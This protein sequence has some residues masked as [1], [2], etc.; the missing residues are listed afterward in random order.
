METKTWMTAKR[1]ARGPEAANAELERWRRVRAE[2]EASAPRRA[3]T[4]ANEGAMRRDAAASRAAHIGSRVAAAP[5]RGIDLL[6]VA[7]VGVMLAGAYAFWRVVSRDRVGA[8]ADN[9]YYV[10]AI[11][12][13]AC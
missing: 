12:L 13:G 1:L 5:E 11:A 3:S 7:L 8:A 4:F 2:R 6:D 10:G 9:P